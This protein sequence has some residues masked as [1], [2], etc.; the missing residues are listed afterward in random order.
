MSGSDEV[1][2][3]QIAEAVANGAT[4]AAAGRRAGVSSMKRD[5][6]W[7]RICA[8]LGSQAR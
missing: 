8:R 6:L 7:M 5:T 3:D 2:M 1:L 4:L